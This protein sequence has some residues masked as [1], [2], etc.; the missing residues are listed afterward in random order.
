MAQIIQYRPNFFTGFHNET[1][2]F[3]SLEEL[4]NIQWVD[5]FRKLTNEQIDPTFYQ[6]SIIKHIGKKGYVYTLMAEYNKGLNW[7]VV[8]IIDDGEIIKEL[9]VW[10]PKY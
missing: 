4:F 1:K 3:N 10:I 7:Y 8:G 5:N 2:T 9:P 6:Y